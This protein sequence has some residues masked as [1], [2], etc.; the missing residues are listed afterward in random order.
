VKTEKIDV[1]LEKAMKGDPGHDL[2]L[3]DYDHLVV[4]P[5]PELE[6]DKTIEVSG[7]FRFPGI[8][9]I[10]R[11]ER[12]SSVIERAGGFTER[13]YLLG[14]VFTRESA[15]AVQQK[16]MDDMAR[17]L[18]ESLLSGAGQTVAMDA[19]EAQMA[20][21]TLEAKKE[22]IQ[23]L[24]NISIDGRVV[25]RLRPLAEFKVSKYDLEME[26]GDMLVV[27]ETP[28]IVTVIGEVFNPTALLYEQG[29]TL[30]YYLARVGGPTKEADRK[31]LALIRADGSVV[32]MTQSSMR[33]IA[34]DKDGHQW[35]FG[36]NFMGLTLDPGDTIVVPRKLDR[37]PWIKSTKDITQIVFQI[38][39]AAGVVFAI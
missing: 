20:K 32:S 21:A 30:E 14:A 1:D 11:G 6:F 7:Q 39:V 12:L 5:I 33:Q 9:P 25:I 8:Y 17:Q 28:G 36:G 35:S 3:Q 26:K 10:C 34:W 22:L 29:N 4:R 27:P 37:V 2:L 23:K 15:K 19:E 24:K 18:E 16:R 13:A 31:Q 38:A